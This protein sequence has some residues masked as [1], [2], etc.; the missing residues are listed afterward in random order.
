VSNLSPEE[1]A[2]LARIARQRWWHTLDLG[3]LG[4]TPGSWDIRHLPAQMPWPAS[5]EGKRCLDVG[6]RDGFWAFEMERRGASEVLGID[7]EEQA[8]DSRWERRHGRAQPAGNAP[9]GVASGY[10]RWRAGETFA[11][12]AECLGSRARFEVLNAYDLSP[13]RVGLFDLVF[14]GYMLHQVRDPLRALEAMRAVCTGSVIVLDAVLYFRS[15]FSRAPLAE[16]GAR[17]GHDDWHYFNAAGLRRVVELA[18][19]RVSGD[20]GF[21]YY[22]PGPGVKA[23]DLPLGTRLRYGLGRAACSLAVRGVVL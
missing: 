19:F 15:V 12:A 13:E 1:V 22:R 20:S 7:I 8:G 11:L 5:L 16:V 21:V 18:G 2:A 3:A 4:V 23:A 6:T 17:R 9:G 14:A 10:N